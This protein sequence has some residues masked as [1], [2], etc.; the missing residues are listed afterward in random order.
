MLTSSERSA[1]AALKRL[2]TSSDPRHLEDLATL[3][4][5]FRE[6]VIPLLG[7]AMRG[8]SIDVRLAA[9]WTL[10]RIDGRQAEEILRR[11]AQDE[12]EDPVV[13][14]FAQRAL[15]SSPSDLPNPRLQPV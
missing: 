2:L 11:A 15:T 4:C 8:D 12:S 7:E 5:C 14:E 13:R 1:L 9:A 3:L 10:S 6:L